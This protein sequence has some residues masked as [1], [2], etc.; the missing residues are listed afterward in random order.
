[1][2]STAPQQPA[3]CEAVRCHCGGDSGTQQHNGAPGATAHKDVATMT[4]AAGE[5]T[6]SY[7]CGAAVVCGKTCTCLA[8]EANAAV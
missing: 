3:G 1:M 5:S 2:L 8:P 6:G 4:K 7:A